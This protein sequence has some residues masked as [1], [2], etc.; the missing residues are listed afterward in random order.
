MSAELVV[1]FLDGA[2]RPA[3][4]E[5]HWWPFLH[6]GDAVEWCV[7]STLIDGER[8]SVVL[9]RLRGM[10]S[11]IVGATIE[12]H[13]HANVERAEETLCAHGGPAKLR[14]STA[15]KTW[16]RSVPPPLKPPPEGSTGL[17]D[18]GLMNALSIQY[19]VPTIDLGSYEIDAELIALVPEDV[20]ARHRVI[21]VSRA[22]SSLV[23]A[24]AD[25]TNGSAVDAIRAATSMQIEPVIATEQAIVA[26]IARYYGGRG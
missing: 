16:L 11:T 4:R 25:P 21:P 19:R 14:E 1:S 26:A 23:V 10:P 13:D 8:I 3:Q 12:S 2:V 5:T 15:T 20:C 9:V 24:V 17:S 18:T 22:G 7:A 6:E